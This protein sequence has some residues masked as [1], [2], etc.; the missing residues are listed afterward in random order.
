MH[1]LR[2]QIIG[3]ATLIS[4]ILVAIAPAR[5]KSN[6]NDHN[7]IA[8]SGVV[9]GNVQKVGFRA[10]IQKQAIKYNLAGSVKNRNDKTVRFILQGDKE[11]DQ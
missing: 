2:R 7:I 9:S 10:M 6:V 5:A 8:I 4:C 1:N 11:A 3:I